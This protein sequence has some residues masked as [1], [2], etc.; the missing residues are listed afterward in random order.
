MT[1]ERWNKIKDLFSGALECPKNE[2]A[3]FLNRV[4]GDDP[5]LKNEVE[6]F[7]ALYQEKDS[8]LEEPAIAQVVN[9]F[10]AETTLG[11]LANSD[12][13]PPRFEAG[14]LL[15]ERYEIERLL[16]RGGM[17]EVYLA[18]DNRIH[19]N[20][21][22][23]VLHSDLVSSKEILQRFAVE[24]QAVSA[25]NHPHIMTIYEFS[26]TDDGTLF[27]VGEYVDGLLLNR[28]IGAELDLERALE[29]AI[30]V[31]SAL[32]AAH[33]AGIT[34]RDIKPENIMIRR[35]GY[36]KVLDFGLAKL[37]HDRK[38]L[39]KSMSEGPTQALHL[40][41][42]GAVMGT[43]AYMSPEQARGI[44][45]DC[46]TDIW[47]LGVVLY[48]MITG[49][50]PF[51]GETTSDIIVSVLSS[52]PSRMAS[53]GHDFPAE[54][55]WIVSK[56][57]SKEVAGRYQTA[58]ELRADLEKIKRQIEFDKTLNRSAG[59]DSADRPPA[60]KDK[61][62]STVEQDFDPTSA[63]V[64][65]PTR[66]GQDTTSVPRPFRSSRSFPGLI[67]QAQNHK[68]GSSIF[69]LFLF[70]LISAVAYLFFT[71]PGGSREIDSIA[72]LPFENLSGNSDLDYV[73]DGLSDSLIDRLS[74]LPQLKVISR[75]SS[76][77]FRGANMVVPE[78][79]S[80][81]GVRAVVT[82]SVA[83]IGDDLLIRF[84]VI[85]A[86]NR[87]ITG[88]Q[89]RRKPDDILSTQN[90]I[91]RT[92]FEH[93]KL[94][95]TDSQS[96]RVAR[97]GTENSEAYRY[98]LSGLV[99]FNSAEREYSNALKHFERSVALDPNFAAAYAEIAFV[100][101]EQANANDNPHELMPKARAANERALSLDPNLAKAHVVKA[102]LK[103]YEFDW[104][105][106]ETEYKKAIDLNPNL[107][108]ARNNYAFFLSVL[109]RQDEALAELE[110]QSIRDPL[111][112][113]L[114]LLQKGI[115][116]AQARRFDE[117]L[118]VYQEVQKLEA[119]NEVPNFALGYVYAGKGLYKKAAE[120]YKKTVDQYGGGEDQYSQPLV[121][122]A[123]T[124][125]KIPEKREDSRRIL[126]R[127]ESMGVY[128][129]PALLA[130]AYA[131]LDDN[132]KAM[133]L[134]EQAYIQRD[135]LLRFIG[136]GYEYDGLRSDPRF[137]DLTKRIGLRQ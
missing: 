46:R 115:I 124:Y 31:S 57:L 41:K 137:I 45:V 112:R 33:E 109:D 71:A 60:K 81:L 8:F 30:Q 105:S 24:A 20:V 100:Y 134:L 126:K 123:A 107:D 55:E 1:K 50:K 18:T 104:Q 70:A 93:L 54:L 69:V 2:R 61:I 113:R 78:V 34:H 119:P 52:E 136:T 73:S 94:K 36:V 129:S 51:S 95:L 49:S 106:A 92:A 59:S 122:L 77:K 25:L 16:G 132:N 131:A 68:V 17:G 12:S 91:A 28:M 63:D 15:N 125:A 21:A 99:E 44:N 11:F 72:V 62:H 39:T 47:S 83:R 65:R 27:F 64:V 85:D 23:K 53:D 5:E 74:Q 66:G 14:I 86:E 10:E 56:A 121:Y 35:D 102:M 82:G 43:A 58:A 37:T 88:G 87:H 80:Q 76:F 98:Y 111:N 117:A 4:C 42:P 29:I 9:L 6:N 7:L 89:Y 114:A 135:L 67:H 97:N 22:L 128:T 96:E 116:L 101:M 84:E 40:T 127:I 26:N 130:A 133:E 19:R 38:P 79:A 118:Q 103:T 48:E 110:Q 120:H 90:E 75:N 108:F 13:S 32:S 3:E